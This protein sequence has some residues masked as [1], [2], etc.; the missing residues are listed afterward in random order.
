MRHPQWQSKRLKYQQ[1]QD[2][3]YAKQIRLQGKFTFPPAEPLDPCVLEAAAENTVQG[4]YRPAAAPVPGK[5]AAAAPKKK[6]S[7]E[8]EEVDLTTLPRADIVAIHTVRF[9]Y[10]PG[11]L[12][13]IFDRA[14]SLTVQYC[15]N[16]TRVGVMGPNG[17]GKS[18]FLKLLTGRLTPTNGSVDRNP[19]AKGWLL[20]TAPLC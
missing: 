18:T 12:P 9:S 1:W 8:E 6:K 15:P 14:I 5:K 16:S 3:Y 20:C 10:N 19:K 2:E 7:A 17:A 13:W 4:I 11:V